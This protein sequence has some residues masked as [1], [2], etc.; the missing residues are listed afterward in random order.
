MICL[1]LGN[2]LL[3]WEWLRDNVRVW[4]E[5]MFIHI[6]YFRHIVLH[7]G[8]NTATQQQEPVLGSL[9]T[10]CL[11][12]WLGR[13]TYVA[14]RPCASCL[15]PDIQQTSVSLSSPGAPYNLV[16]FFLKHVTL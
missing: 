8:Q 5:F 4:T 14:P 6:Q 16:L 2:A 13:V 11:A 7:K 12:S 10:M 3:Y 9:P 15:G 1:F